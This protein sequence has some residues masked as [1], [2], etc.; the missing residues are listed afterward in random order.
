[1]DYAFPVGADA[2][3]LVDEGEARHAVP[4]GLA[5]DG[6][7]LGLDAAH[8]AENHDSTVEDPQAPL[9]LDGEVHVA[10][11]VNQVDRQTLPRKGRGGGVDRDAALLLFRVEVHDGR[12]FVD[13]AHLVGFAGVIQDALG[14]RGLAGVN[15]S[16]NADISDLG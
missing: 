1:M 9:D 8:S 7:A 15:V 13:L 4:V 6:L 3:Y 2:V 16:G 11:R 12:A 14:D 10:R 5:P